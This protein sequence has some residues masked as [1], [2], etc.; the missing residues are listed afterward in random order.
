MI[1][2]EI[3]TGTGD[4]PNGFSPG[5]PRPWVACVCSVSVAGGS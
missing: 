1:Q 5:D 2:I 4:R 3:L